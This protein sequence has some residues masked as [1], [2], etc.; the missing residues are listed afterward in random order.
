MDDTQGSPAG[1]RVSKLLAQRGLCSRREADA[2]IE[3]GLVFVNGQRVTEL[4]TRAPEDA[5]I[6][7][8]AEAKAAQARQVTILIHKPMGYV[9]GQ[10]E[11]GHQPAVSLVGA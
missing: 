9:S 8:A 2:F 3:R 1:I 10:A 4:G 5:V 7:L 6:T 11:D